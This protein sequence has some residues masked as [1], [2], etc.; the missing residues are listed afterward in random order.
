MLHYQPPNSP[1]NLIINNHWFIPLVINQKHRQIISSL[2]SPSIKGQAMTIILRNLNGVAWKCAWLMLI[3]CGGHLPKLVLK[4]FNGGHMRLNFVAH[5]KM[6][7]LISLIQFSQLFDPLKSFVS[8]VSILKLYLYYSSSV[9]RKGHSY[10]YT[11]LSIFNHHL[12]PYS[13]LYIQTYYCSWLHSSS[14]LDSLAQSYN[15]FD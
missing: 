5:P 11:H 12:S 8:K 9:E 13:C 3:K 10:I 2:S 15:F 7:D 1:P 4:L 14:N 6:S